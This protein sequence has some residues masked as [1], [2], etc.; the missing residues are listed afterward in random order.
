MLAGAAPVTTL[1]AQPV[2]E[3]PDWMYSVTVEPVSQEG[4][5][6]LRV[7]VWQED[8]AGDL[9]NLDIRRQNQFALVRWIRDPHTQNSPDDSPES[10][11]SLDTLDL[12]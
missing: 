1:E 8:A 5:A 3:C 12:R 10:F 11:P 2:E 4:V 7:A 6:A 9:Q